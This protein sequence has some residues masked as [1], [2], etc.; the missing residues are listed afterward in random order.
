MD[1]LQFMEDCHLLENV[2]SESQKE[3]SSK[4]N[5][6]VAGDSETADLNPESTADFGHSS[7]TEDSSLSLQ[8]LQCLNLSHQSLLKGKESK[9]GLEQYPTVEE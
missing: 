3:T 8:H 5:D 2:T 7:I 6:G 4:L 9:I 1:Y